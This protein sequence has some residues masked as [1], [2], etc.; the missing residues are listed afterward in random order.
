MADRLPEGFFDDP[1]KDAEVRQV[2]YQS[3]IDEELG[4][5]KKAMKEMT[6]ESEAIIDEDDKINE[7]ERSLSNIDEL[8]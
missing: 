8:M 3:K 4:I 6:Q 5:F 1:V 2:P 7:V